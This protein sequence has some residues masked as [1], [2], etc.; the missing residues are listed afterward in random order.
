MKSK[1]RIYLK[2]WNIYKPYKDQV[3]TDSYYLKVCNE[4]KSIIEADKN[5]SF[6]MEFQADFIKDLAI[7]LTNYFEDIISETNIW[8]IFIQKHKELYQKVLPFFDTENYYEKEINESDIAFLIWY[9]TSTMNK[10]KVYSIG[11]TFYVLLAQDIIEVFDEHYEYAPENTVLKDI[12]TF[13]ENENNYYSAR[14]FIDN[15]VFSSYLFMIDIGFDFDRDFEEYLMTAEE[16]SNLKSYFDIMRDEKIFSSHTKLLALRP[17]EWAAL[18]VGKSHTLY[19]NFLNLSQKISGYFLYKRQDANNLYIEHIASSKEFIVTKKSIDNPKL[20]KDKDSIVY[21]GIVI[22]EN[23]WWFSGIFIL[24]EFDADLILDEKN[25]IKSRQ[26]ISF[27]EKNTEDYLISTKMQ[28]DFFI[29]FNGS[30]I[31]FLEKEEINNF[32][33]YYIKSYNESLNI[34]HKELKHSEKR[35]KIDGFFGGNDSIDFNY[36]NNTEPAILFYNKNTGIE[37]AFLINNAFPTRLNDSYDKNQNKKDFIQ[38]LF[39]NSYSKELVLYCIENYKNK[40]PFLKTFYGKKIL[41][42]LDFILR[43]HKNENYFSEGR[44]V[45]I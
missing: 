26:Q 9:F 7:F 34:N 13:P 39:N 30:P 4:V 12:Y 17:N 32:L 27:L 40:I 22:W 29:H 23:E 25:S 36:K 24:K 31:V 6:L 10:N 33:N 8:N 5:Y 19:N 37:T 14:L 3:S 2:D 11:N 1:D 21:M 16:D 35:F 38:L 45:I 43:Y 41:K 18:L 44:I 15:I 28:Y 20:F 42:D